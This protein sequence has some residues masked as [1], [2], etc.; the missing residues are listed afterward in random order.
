[1]EQL[2]PPN[3][4]LLSRSSPVNNVEV[5][6]TQYEGATSI[7]AKEELTEQSK[8]EEVD[9]IKQKLVSMRLVADLQAYL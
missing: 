6:E 4:S 3:T 7:M 2:S 9:H 1:M 5:G 8:E